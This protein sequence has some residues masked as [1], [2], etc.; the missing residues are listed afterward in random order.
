MRNG[1]RY[2][3]ASGQR[4]QSD[5]NEAVEP[6]KRTR[7]S[8]IARRASGN[9]IAEEAPELVDRAAASS[10]AQLPSSLRERFENSL[11]TDLSSVRIHT[12]AA[13][14]DAA[15]AVSAKAYTDGHDIHFNDGFYQPDSTEGQKLI[16]HEVAHTV[17]QGGASRGGSFEVSEPGDALERE[18]D[19]AAAAMLSGE[20]AQVSSAQ[21]L[22]RRVLQRD[23]LGEIDLD[24]HIQGTWAQGA[25]P[26]PTSPE[27]E[28]LAAVPAVPKLNNR[29]DKRANA[30]HDKSVGG[31]E[32]FS[33]ALLDQ[34]SAWNVAVPKLRAFFIPGDEEQAQLQDLDGFATKAG[35]KQTVAEWGGRQKTGALDN[36][37]TVDGAFGGKKGTDLKLSE[38]DTK[39]LRSAGADPKVQRLLDERVAAEA[40][41]AGAAST[42]AG[43]GSLLKSAA[44]SVDAAFSEVQIAEEEK[45]KE[46]KQS[47]IA[48]VNAAKTKAK[49][50]AK[51]VLDLAKDMRGAAGSAA[52]GDPAGGAID[53]A[54]TLLKF[55]KNAEIDASYAPR[56]AKAAAA[57]QAATSTII[58]LGITKANHTLTAASSQLLAAAAAVK[59]AEADYKAKQIALRTVY[60]TLASEVRSSSGGDPNVGKRLEAAIAGISV[61]RSVI[62][63]GGEATS[64]LRT[65]E[66]T[67]QA[68]IGFSAA[69]FDASGAQMVR[70]YGRMKGYPQQIQPDVDMWK[71]RLVSMQK[72]IDELRAGNTRIE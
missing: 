12:G 10:G 15:A 42:V 11:Q 35:E 37:T 71:K 17:Q 70:I 44:A 5:A 41:V 13:S 23:P 31:R 43:T 32:A 56:V 1:R 33:N 21:G 29:G 40:A 30:R 64:S 53:G 59:Q 6:G 28:A 48:A 57:V 60:K 54:A 55:A 20:T 3:E 19:G 9:E 47:G 45:E 66:P 67:T 39:G 38:N 27:V 51:M 18:A 7:T 2:E 69:M 16:A 22:A 26:G 61:V 68:R 49:A 34:V 4:A 63:R 50:E 58:S 8:L 36:D 25:Q 24:D 72:I 14:S 62:T 46:A 52:G 65:V